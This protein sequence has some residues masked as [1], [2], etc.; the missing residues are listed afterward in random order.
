LAN[1]YG[2]WPHLVNPSACYRKNGYLRRDSPPFE[3]RF[4]TINALSS[5][6]KQADS[7]NVAMSRILARKREKER[8]R[9][10]MSKR[11]KTSN[12][13]PSYVAERIGGSTLGSVAI[14]LADRSAIL[15]NDMFL[16]SFF[17]SCHFFQHSLYYNHGYGKSEY[18]LRDLLVYL[19]EEE[20]AQWNMH[21]RRP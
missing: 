14:Y 17:P 11:R 2:S 4:C 15:T 16:R 21:Q 19:T 1:F 5:E 12:V 8:K 20:D 3:R 7:P 13:W 9:Q 18:L 6:R 10:T